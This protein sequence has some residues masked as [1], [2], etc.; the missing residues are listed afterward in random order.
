M[1]ESEQRNNPACKAFASEVAAHLE[2]E[3]RPQV[4]EHARECTACGAVLADLE[5]IRS[6]ARDLPLAE[7]APALWSNL[8]AKLAAEG[9][10]AAPA[11]TLFAAELPDYLEGEARPLVPS[12]AEQCRP[13]RS[14]LEDF[15]A[16]RR[17]AAELPLEEP[18]PAVWANVRARLD[19][20]G[21]FGTP[22]QGW[23]QILSWRFLQHPLP[24]GALAML[25]LMGS[26]LTLGPSRLQTRQYGSGIEA[27][28]MDSDAASVFANLSAGD[29]DRS[30]AFVVS[31]LE[32]EFRASEASMAPDLK[33]TYDKSL[34]SLDDSIHECLSSLQDEPRNTLAH[35]YLMAAY[36]RKAEVLSTALEFEGR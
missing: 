26:A 18:A 25:I 31:K 23:R 20:E 15:T 2:G 12:H 32:R 30:P 7:P 8:R 34:V 24:A 6:A 11:C 36:T 29:Q 3:G 4:A 35:D 27:V 13:C 16:L 28:A 33:A 1:A 22:V 21:A 19:A 9:A 17:A 10:F 14:L 5:A